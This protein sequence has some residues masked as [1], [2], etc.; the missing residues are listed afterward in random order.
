MSQP[1]SAF[2]LIYCTFPDVESSRL[3]IEE[4]LKQQL[5]CCANISAPVLSMYRWAG[6]LQQDTEHVVILKSMVHHE[7]AIYEYIRHRHP[8]ECPCVCTLPTQNVSAD[9][10]AWMRGC[11]KN[12]EE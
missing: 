6:E 8:Y 10:M 5:I 11:L 9:Y 3:I 2:I 1:S 4:L 12:V 7:A